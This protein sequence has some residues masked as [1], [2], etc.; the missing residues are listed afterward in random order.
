MRRIFLVIIAFLLSAA[1]SFSKDVSPLKVGILSDVH[2]NNE[3]TTKYFVKALE[4]FRN[5]DVD[6]VMIAGDMIG[7][8][9]EWQLE[10]FSQKWYSVFPDDRGLNGKKI[11]KLFVY[12]NHEIVGHKY[13]S[14]KS[15]YT[16]EEIALQCIANRR[17]ELW[18]KYFH[19]DFEPIYIKDVKGYKFIGAHF[20]TT[21]RTS[22]LEEFFDAVGRKLPKDKPFFY[23][24]HT[25]PK[26]T[27]S[28]ETVWGQDNGESTELLKRYPN[29]IAFSGHSHTTLTDERTIWQGEFTS[30]GTGSLAYAS[31]LNSGEY[32]NGSRK[33][34]ENSQ[35]EAFPKRKSHQGQLMTV[36]TD[37]VELLRHDFTYDED[38]GTWT[39]PLGTGEKPY[40][41]DFRAADTPAP[42]F[43]SDAKVSV[44]CKDD[45]Q[46]R[47]KNTVQQ[48][49]V[50][51]PSIPS[52]DARP[53]AYEFT[54]EAVNADNG[55]VL[56]SKK[57]LSGGFFLGEKRDVKLG[58]QCVFAVS[59]L[60]SG[61]PVR[62]A[63]YPANCFGRKGEPVYSE[64]I[65]L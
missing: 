33:K 51:F 3:N 19:E 59:E 42:E 52:C 18:K 63:V 47:Q 24:Q 11:V 30:V 50:K 56:A 16:E 26:G 2:C 38:L 54:V 37:R 34:G 25:H 35:M 10:L 60:P 36:Y 39:I 53:R 12:G 8:G 46:D 1:V 27:C 58:S 62:F 65:T 28:G 14:P 4:Y 20:Q 32:E 44:S 15:R 9:L 7:W 61:M 49:F 57:V 45:G 23:F 41:I 21:R 55:S 13:S 17:E 29:V 64:T 31:A 6:A 48:I 40:S 22:G 5:N 43:A